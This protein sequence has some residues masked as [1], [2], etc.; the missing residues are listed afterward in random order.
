MRRALCL[1]ILAAV[2]ILPAIVAAQEFGVFT[3]IIRDANTKEPLIGA[4]IVLKEDVTFGAAT[5]IDGRF[6]MQL[7]P[8]HYHF[9]VSFTGM[10]TDSVEI[11]I[12]ENQIVHREI[13][14][15][16]FINE[17]D[18]IEVRAGRFDQRIEEITVSMEIIK[19]DLI[20]NKNTR[21]IMTILDFTPGVNIM[22]NEPQ[23]R[24]GS[25]FTF[26]VG[27]KVGIIVDDIPML[28]GDA[29]RPYWDFIPV[30][31]IEQI[32]VIKGAASVLSGSSAISGAI[33]IRTAAPG[34]KPM[35][36][37]QAYT[38]VYSAPEDRSM[39][40]WDDYPYIVGLNFLHTRKAG[41]VDITLGGTASLD[42]GA[43]GGPIG[44]QWTTAPIFSDEE[45]VSQKIRVN[46]N[47]RK[48]SGKIQGLNFGANGNLMYHK[49][50]MV[51]VWHD[52]TSGFYRTYPG[53]VMIQ[54]M[55][56]THIDPYINLYSNSGFKHSFRSRILYNTNDQTN[57][58][59]IKSLMAY[60]DYNFTREYDFLN[61]LNFIGGLS[62]QYSNVDAEMY[63]GAGNRIND[64]FNMSAYA[65][66][67]NNFLRIINLSLGAR[68]E[69]Y[70]MTDS[71]SE[72][73]PIFRAGMSLKVF[74]ETYFRVSI[75]QGYRYPTIAEKFI[76]TPVGSFAMYENTGLQAES[77]WNAEFGLKQGFKFLNYFG[78]FD[79]ALFQQEYRNTI[80]FLFGFWDTTPVAGEDIRAGFKFHNTGKSK[81]SG[82]DVSL[83]GMAKIG[84]KGSLKTIIG[85]TIIQ[86]VT[87]QPDYVF[88]TDALGHP[89]S[90]N[91][92]SVNPSK[93]YLKYRF[94]NTFKGD[95]EFNY[96]DFSIGVSG[97]YFS[98][99]EN[100]DAAIIEFEHATKQSGTMVPILYEQYFNT[101][102]NG[103]FI[104]DAR[105]SYKLSEHHKLAMISDNLLNRAYSLR[106][107][108]AEP[109]RTVMVQ[110]S[111]T[112]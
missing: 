89:L 28:S 43:F 95:I 72:I 75:G 96:S 6:S 21:S 47:I 16:P 1:A 22:D 35:T 19:P 20:E 64:A 10:K 54:N 105:V 108:K 51:L 78:Y 66:I 52:D 69:Y 76:R 107:L 90:Y 15:I 80:E 73:K 13:S 77:S 38:G 60:A 112:M 44:N 39:K 49:A 31:N 11:T 18:G 14:L 7:R 61:G 109:M 102:N 55:F 97:R 40:W 81:I 103:N 99:I 4:N 70:D 45:M 5:G 92:S 56:I 83:T 79:L 86:P 93:K 17:L 53:A 84:R 9:Q 57:D 25:G 12:R 62:S 85:E 50:P 41:D 42:H 68:I 82:I 59:S 98:K 24:G 87:L 46:Y 36:K 30:E 104:L 27:S 2:L 91:S 26:G 111:F 106:P 88:A 74:R 94:L 3:G 58:Q 32:E 110:Y 101:H 23:I 100:L 65:Q 67:E 8:G 71:D 48:R 33:H 37:I 63:I 34:L 29:G